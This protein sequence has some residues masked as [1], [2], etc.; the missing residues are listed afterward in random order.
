MAHQLSMEVACRLRQQLQALTNDEETAHSLA[1]GNG[2]WPTCI[3][4]NTTRVCYVTLA[5]ALRPSERRSTSSVPAGWTVNTEFGL[6][7]ILGTP[8]KAGLAQTSDVVVL[9]FGSHFVPDALVLGEAS[10]QRVLDYVETLRIRPLPELLW[11]ENPA[12]HFPTHSG[13]WFAGINPKL[14]QTWPVVDGTDPTKPCTASLSPDTLD[15]ANVV[16]RR[17]EPRLR[18]ARIPILRLWNATVSRGHDHV[19]RW[20]SYGYDC[21]HF[22][23][24][25]S[26]LHFQ[27]D[28]LFAYVADLSLSEVDSYLQPEKT[29]HSTLFEAD[30]SG[31]GLKTTAGSLTGHKAKPIKPPKPP[32]PPR[33][34]V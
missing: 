19:G 13:V 6:S 8:T 9:S 5:Y 26:T 16:N 31:S 1:V 20:R 12:Q 21:N 22:C 17:F 3:E 28:L 29:R 32:K 15:E 25:S 2:K 10:L 7:L 23:E 30:F 27:A 4:F 14:L 24:P 33:S 11:R 18:R 34:G